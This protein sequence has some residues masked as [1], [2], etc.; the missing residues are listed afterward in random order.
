M[1]DN[2]VPWRWK[3]MIGNYVTF[4]EYIN[5]ILSRKHYGKRRKRNIKK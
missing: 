1:I 4:R 3:T 2:Y 5:W